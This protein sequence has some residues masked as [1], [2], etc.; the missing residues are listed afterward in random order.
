[1][2]LFNDNE[3]K[4]F[5]LINLTSFLCNMTIKLYSFLPLKLLIRS[6]MYSIVYLDI[7]R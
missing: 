4:T 1:M 2:Y 5:C 3:I 7:F 6:S